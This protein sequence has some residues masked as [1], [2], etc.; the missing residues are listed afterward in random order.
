[1]SKASEQLRQLASD[2]RKE[3]DT[4]VLAR[5]E[6]ATQIVKAATGLGLLRMK[7]GGTHA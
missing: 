2:L 1:M 6:K 5:R 4:R 3:A 7:L